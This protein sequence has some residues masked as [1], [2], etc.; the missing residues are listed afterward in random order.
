[1]YYLPLC[2]CLFSSLC[3]FRHYWWPCTSRIL[4]SQMWVISQVISSTQP[5]ITSPSASIRVTLYHLEMH[6]YNSELVNYCFG[7]VPFWHFFLICLFNKTPK[8]VRQTL[9]PLTC[10]ICCIDSSAQNYN[11]LIVY[12]LEL[13]QSCTKPSILSKNYTSLP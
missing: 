9:V 11:I 5:I 6:K 12:A 10:N 13:P 8:Q 3:Y 2:W 7:K 1:M 4:V